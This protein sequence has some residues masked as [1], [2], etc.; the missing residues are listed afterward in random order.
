MK[1]NQTEREGKYIFKKHT[2][3]P[4]QKT[5]FRENDTGDCS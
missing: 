2:P 4:P 5:C 3:P 1:V